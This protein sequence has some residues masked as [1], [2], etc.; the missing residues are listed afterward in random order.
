LEENE[1]KDLG[2]LLNQ[3]MESIEKENAGELAGVLPRDYGLL[4]NE[5]LVKLLKTFSKLDQIE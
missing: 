4:S 1:S 2:K 3:A 5:N